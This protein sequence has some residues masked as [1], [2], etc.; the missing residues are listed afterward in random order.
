VEV[1]S[2]VGQG[3]TFK[4]YLPQAEEA[5]AGS[6]EHEEVDRGLQ[7][8]T[9]TVLLAEDE[10]AVRN[11]IVNL[12]SH[13]GYHVLEAANGVEALALAQE[14]AGREIHLLLTDVVM[15]QMG[16]IE[17]ARQL[18]YLRPNT[19]IL[20]V[21]GYS[22]DPF[23]KLGIAD[24]DTQFMQKPFDPAAVARKVREVMDAQASTVS[25]LAR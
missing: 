14:H 18:S 2:K 9:E 8:G 15:P 20:F 10:P 17:L 16:G 25:G 13:Q 3:T 6:S 22:T 11:P 24:Q 7:K 4:I 1:Y 19:K 12:L 5:V 21:S 23:L